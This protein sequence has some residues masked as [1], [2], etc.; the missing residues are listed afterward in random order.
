M[1]IKIM[2]IFPEMFEGFINTSIIKRAIE[3]GLIEIEVIDFR[4]YS[5][6]KNKRVDDY[7]YGGGA[8][9]ILAC[10]PILDCLKDI[11]SDNSYVVITDP[12]GRKFDQSLA[13]DYSSKEE[14]III[15]GHYE[16][17]DGRVYNFVD[18]K[19]S[20]GDFVLTGGELASMVICDAVS[21]LVNGVISSDSTS[22]ESF[23]NNLLEYQQ[24]TRPAVYQSM[25]VPEVL[26]SGHHENIRR[27]RLKEQLKNTYLYRRDLL[28]LHQFT[29]EEKQLMQEILAEL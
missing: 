22:E 21:R 26:L 7:P 11:K 13:K 1:K 3:K 15:C 2:T 6:D 28:Q 17:F 10:Q 12:A 25:A 16:G 24:Y 9:M 5:T 23:E 4:E 20:I 19:V 18:E 14:L 27:Y 8:G 29:D